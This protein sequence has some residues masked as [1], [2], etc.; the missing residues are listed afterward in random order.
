MK[1]AFLILLAAG[2]A[3]VVLSA[4]APLR[5]GAVVALNAPAPAFRLPKLGGGLAS[6]SD[7]SGQVVLINFWATWCADCRREMPALEKLYRRLKGRG[8]SVAAVCL[9]QDGRR[10]AA[11]FVSRN[12][13][14]HPVLLGDGRTADAY[15]VRGLPTSY[16]LDQSGIAVRRYI[17]AVEPDVLENDILALL[18]RRKNR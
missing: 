16:L 3:A 9:D 7:F 1:R 14:T 17:G 6:L 12:G 15:G 8:F 4:V 5:R 18:E 13:L 2:S 10:S 11:P